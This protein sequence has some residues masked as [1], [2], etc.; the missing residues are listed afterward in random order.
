MDYY[1]TSNTLDTLDIF[2]PF[3]ER[4]EVNKY[5]FRKFIQKNLM[6]LLLKITCAAN[7][8]TTI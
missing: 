7:H 4:K 5:C 3:A 2:K 6:V 8:L 1:I